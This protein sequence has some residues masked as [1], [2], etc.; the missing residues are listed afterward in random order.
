MKRFAVIGKPVAHSKS[1][2]MFNRF[3]RNKGIDAVYTRIAS[4]NLKDALKTCRLLNIDGINATMPFKKELLETVDFAS[5]EA[6]GVDGVNT[7]VFGNQLK[8]HNTDIYGALMPLKK[9]LKSLKDKKILIIGAGGAARAALYA[10][11]KENAICYLSNRTYEKG[12]EQAKKF[13]AYVVLFEKIN[14]ILREIDIICYTIP[15]KIDLDISQIKP[16]AIFFTAI[17]NQHFFKEECKKKGI[18]YIPGEEWLIE[19]G[20][21]ACSLFGFDCKNGFPDSILDKAKPKNRIALIGFMGS[22]KSTAGKLLA[23]KLD[24]QFIDLDKSIE[25]GEGKGIPEIFNNFGESYFRNLE[26]RYLSELKDKNRIVLATGG[27]IVES[28]YCFDMLKDYFFNI[29]LCGNPED[30]FRRTENSSRPLR[31]GS[32]FFINLYR[33]RKDKYLMLSDLILNSSIYTPEEISDIIYYEFC[34][35]L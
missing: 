34:K 11:K 4:K 15:V 18:I 33:K 10:Y 13:G 2:Q 27:G 12:R 26:Y 23:K 20:K 25:K 19:Q 29:F 8:G 1:P 9:R 32:N 31:K 30:F 5:D 17:Y 22:G 35:V 21:V 7:V 3:F 14:S 28:Q 6:K 16:S 24:Y